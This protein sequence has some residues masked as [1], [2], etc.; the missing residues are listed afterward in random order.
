M[1]RFSKIILLTIAALASF[2]AQAQVADNLFFDNFG[3]VSSNLISGDPTER[4]P[5]EYNNPRADDVIWSKVVYRVLDLREKI[6][7]PLYFPTVAGDHRQSLF[8][9]I[10]RLFEEGAIDVYEFDADREVFDSAHMVQFDKFIESNNILISADVDSI[11][12][13]TTKTWIAESDIPNVDVIKY[14]LKEVWFFDKNNSTFGVKI[15]AI[16]PKIYRIEEEMGG[17][18]VGYPQFWVPF[19]KL[20]PF[21]A[22]QE[23]LSS[24]RNNGARETVDDLFIKRKFGSYIYKESNTR[25]RNLMEYN[26]TAKQAHREQD[27]IK[28]E[29]MNFEQD[30]WEY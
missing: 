4:T 27:R 28:R 12:G 8:T 9:T 6:N 2:S 5:I 21:L 25:N 17:R 24:D 13:D 7:Y 30:L 16:C 11:T 22:Q 15:I 26:T 23:I 3:E 19:S 10:F 29:I 1:K 14:Y 18:L 20:R